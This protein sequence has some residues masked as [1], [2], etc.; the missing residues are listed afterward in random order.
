MKIIS[1]Q[2]IRSLNISPALCVEWVKESFALKERAQLPA[3]ISLHPQGNDFFNTMPCLLPEP[4]NCFGVKIVH[5][6]KGATPTL[7]GDILLYNSQNGELLAMLDA[8]WI[9]TM[10]TGA[11]ATLAMQTLRKNN[12]QTYGFIGLGN[13]GR[14]TMLCLLESE[15]DELHHILLLRYKDQA[16]QFIE[17]FKNY[18]NAS[19]SICNDIKELVPQSDVIVSCI[20]EAQGLLCDNDSLYKK[21]CL[22]VPVHTRG[23]QNCDLCFDKVFADDTAHVCGFKYFNQFRQFA[24]LQDVIEGKKPG[25]DSDEDRILSYNIGLGLHD[26][27]FA[28]KI[29]EILGATAHNVYIERESDKFWI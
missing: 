6:I 23:F 27:L 14:A 15:P 16:E 2:Q 21:G 9:T 1:Q 24:E 3:K 26:V 28:S 10:R 5:R 4:Y 8:D 12:T 7:G 25:R 19:F 29:Y 17:R 20:T 13:T 22:V 11:V 18:P